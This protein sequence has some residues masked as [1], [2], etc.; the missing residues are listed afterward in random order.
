MS[1]SLVIPFQVKPTQ[2]E[3]YTDITSLGIIWLVSCRKLVAGE[4]MVLH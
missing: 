4:G 3:E 1:V 2:N